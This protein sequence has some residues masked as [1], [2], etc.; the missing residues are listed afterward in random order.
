[1][2]KSRTGYSIASRKDRDPS[3]FD[4][5]AMKGLVEEKQGIPVKSDRIEE[6]IKSLNEKLKNMRST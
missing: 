4:G 1:M 6:G 2:G 5:V 3:N